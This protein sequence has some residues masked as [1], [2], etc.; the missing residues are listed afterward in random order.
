MNPIQIKN[1]KLKGGYENPIKIPDKIAIN[2]LFFLKMLFIYLEK[3]EELKL[4]Q[5]NQF[6]PYFSQY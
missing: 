4:K 6:F 5:L 3:T 1:P 2:A